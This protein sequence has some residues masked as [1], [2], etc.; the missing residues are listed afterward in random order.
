MR[1]KDGPSI[2]FYDFFNVGLR[3]YFYLENKFN[4]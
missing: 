2:G 1:G 4:K 3:V